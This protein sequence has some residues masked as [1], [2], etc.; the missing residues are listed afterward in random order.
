MSKKILKFPSDR[1]DS[2]EVNK[3][4]LGADP[5]NDNDAVSKKYV[6]SVAGGSI[7]SQLTTKKVTFTLENGATEELDLVIKMPD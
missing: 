1:V 6:D 2:I 5:V 4:T 3:I 7:P